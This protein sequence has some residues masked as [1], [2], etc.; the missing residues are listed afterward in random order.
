MDLD[1]SVVSS[2]TSSFSKDVAGADRILVAA[3]VQEAVSVL[4]QDLELKQS[5]GSVSKYVV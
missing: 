1:C 2:A 3:G 5:N 4:E